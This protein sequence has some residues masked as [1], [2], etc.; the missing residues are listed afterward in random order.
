MKGRIPEAFIDEVIARADIVELIHN[1]VTLKKSGKNYVA[2]CPFHNEKTP[3]FTV[4][5]EKQ[6]YYCFGCGASGNVISFLMEY[7]RL[8]FIESVQSLAH[9]AG[10]KIPLEER[11]AAE[12]QQYK[13]LTSA[14]EQA[15]RFFSQQLL[16][17]SPASKKARQYLRDRGLNNEVIDLFKLGYAPPGWDNLIQH[18]SLKNS[19]QVGTLSG[20]TIENDKQ[21]HYDRFRDR[22]MFPIADPRG[23]TIAFGGR[24]MGDEKPKYLNSPETPL[25]HK[26]EVL[27]G[28][29]EYLSDKQTHRNEK[30]K[31]FLI[32]EGYLDV[33]AL[34][35]HQ[36]RFAVATLGTATSRTH[37][38]KLFRHAPEIVFCFD[39][40]KAGRKAAERALSVTLPTLQAG[41]EVK[42]LFLP[43]G[44]DPDTLIRKEGTELFLNRVNNATPLSE[45]LFEELENQVNLQTVDGKAKLAALASPYL[46]EIPEGIYKELMLDRLAKLAGL[47]VETLVRT[48]DT[49]PKKTKAHPKT[50]G[51]TQPPTQNHQ[52]PGSGH[53]HPGKDQQDYLQQ[54]FTQAPPPHPLTQQDYPEHAPAPYQDSSPNNASDLLPQQDRAASQDIDRS[55]LLVERT[56]RPLLQSPEKAQQI[57]IPEEFK[58]VD[59][60]S[61]QFLIG[62]LEF[63]KENP[64]SNTASLIGHWHGT[65]MGEQIARMAAKEF[66]LNQEQVETEIQDAILQLQRLHITELI[67]KQIETDRN[68]KTKDG[69]KLKKLLELKQ[70]IGSN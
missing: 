46:S 8:S 36:V 45:H 17:H 14:L 61:V 24:V 47:P 39:G 33:I 63:L 37:L 57:E 12:S 62:T 11:S 60:K 31:K 42:F 54:G 70:A 43:E 40:D 5:R 20:L 64:T 22:I 51:T 15:Q 2:C 38:E 25:F 65:E 55:L 29:H 53:Q 10:L 1:Q 4:S 34:Y 32:V 68:S 48:L 41:R 26:Q 49:Q 18:L 66:L 30:A 3:S 50:A 35:Q 16:A 6:F 28:L 52:H 21:R 59:S 23:R 19:P 67:S 13:Q 27:Y 58:Q 9:S 44:E 7:G 69:S 56:I